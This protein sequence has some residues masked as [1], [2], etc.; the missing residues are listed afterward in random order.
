[1]E[2][3]DATENFTPDVEALPLANDSVKVQSLLSP[4][5]IIRLA[6]SITYAVIVAS[7]SWIRWAN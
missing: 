7:D 1:M 6:L 3:E 2:I 5:S 4:W